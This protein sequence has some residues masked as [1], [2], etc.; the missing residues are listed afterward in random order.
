MSGERASEF[1]AVISAGGV[2]LFPSDTVYGLAC[3]PENE[4]AIERLYSLKGRPPDK[5][6]AVMFFDLATGLAALGQLGP[7]TRAA[8]ERLMPGGVTVLLRNP[9]HLFPLACRADP[10][11]LGVR[12]V[13]VP[14]LRGASV[15]VLQSSANPSGGADARTLAAVAPA[16][17]AGVNL[18]IDGGELP[19]RASTV[20][21][22]REYEHGHVYSVPRLGAVEVLADVLDGRFRFHPD[23]YLELV[24]RDLPDYERLQSQLV[25]ASGS[26]ARRIL[27][28]GT[29]TGET[30]AR[31][32]ARHPEAVLEAVDENAEMLAVAGQRLGDRLATA[33]VA[34]LQ[35]PLPSGP[36][37]LVTSAL[38]IHHLDGPEKADLYRRIAQVLSPG[39]RFVLADLVVPGDPSLALC[40]LAPGYDKPSTVPD[41]LRWLQDAGLEATVVWER[42]DLAVIVAERS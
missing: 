23:S 6:A 19:G 33:H 11:T 41:Q 29:G 31:V 20:I 21:D 35:E 14:L 42:N 7:R 30:A 22:L 38:A 40:E 4:A 15:A 32:L 9:D 13:D 8:L 36:F 12:I 39:G 5:S 26:G 16:M 25:E 37:D 28:L 3:D 17:R 10:D 34:M 24:N 2:V 18:E 27:D 1:E